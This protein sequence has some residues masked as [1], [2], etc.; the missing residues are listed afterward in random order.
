MG[1]VTSVEVHP[2][3]RPVPTTGRPLALVGGVVAFNEERNIEPALRSLLEQR[4]PPGAHW[5]SIWV[6]ASG[7]T[8][9]TVPIV[10]AFAEA[11]SLVHLI[12]EKERGGKA[13]AL[14]RIL[15]TAEGDVLVLLNSD[16]RA[17]PGSVAALLRSAADRP[18]PFAVMAQPVVP[19]GAAT[20]V[21]R[22]VRLM[23]ALHH[24]FHAASLGGGRGNHLS[25]ELLLLSLPGVP[26]LPVGVINDGSYV[27]L[28]LAGRGGTL[29]YAPEARVAIQVPATL[30]D[31][32]VQR[33]RILVG[34]AQMT[35]LMGR[36][37]ST[38]FRLFLHD[39]EAAIRVLWHGIRKEPGRIVDLSLL[40]FPEVAAGCLALWDRLP[41]QRDHRNWQRIRQPARGLPSQ[42]GP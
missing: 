3:S 19:Q 27:G 29:L 15:R 5:A 17:E 21:D 40:I 26:G 41:P 30:G 1:A 12:V 25:D 37:P 36:H 8:D 22:I 9:R 23:W 14:D 39:P 10:E 2:V 24:E 18:G 20:P 13:Q 7:C 6:V 42:S 33:R 4:L 31:H 32:L 35:R 16:A 11:H 28:W 38:L 34:H